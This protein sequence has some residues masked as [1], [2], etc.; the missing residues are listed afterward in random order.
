MVDIKINKWPSTFG[1]TIEIEE[2]LLI[3]GGDDAVSSITYNT[4]E[5]SETVMIIYAGSEVKVPHYSWIEKVYMS[6]IHE[7]LIH[8]DSL[9]VKYMDD[10]NKICNVM[11]DGMAN[12]IVLDAQICGNSLPLGIT[13]DSDGR[14]ADDVEQ[15]TLMNIF[16]SSDTIV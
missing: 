8:I 4:S 7:F 1:E 5:T 11:I 15:T 2:D 3:V 16:G 6:G 9:D 13:P 12:S 10:T 14:F